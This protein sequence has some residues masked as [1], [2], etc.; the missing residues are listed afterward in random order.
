MKT[1]P[2]RTLILACAAGLAVALIGSGVLLTRSPAPA[3]SA[4][5]GKDIQQQM[6][7]LAHP[8]DKAW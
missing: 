6:K 2:R 5:V 7:E 4:A 1:I 8:V 3:S